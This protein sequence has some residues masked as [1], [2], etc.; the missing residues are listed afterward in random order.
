MQDL[1]QTGHISL[2]DAQLRY[3]PHFLSSEAADGLF[4][5]LL[6]QVTWKEDSIRI[7][8]KTYPQPRLTALYGDRGKSYAYSGIQMH[9]TPFTP[10]LL[11]LKLR[12][13]D[14]SGERFT[15]C[16]P[17]CLPRFS[18]KAQGGQVPEVSYATWAWE[19]AADGWRHA[20]ILVTS[21][22]QNPKNR[23]ET[24]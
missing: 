18:L 10:E 14:L 6:T 16:L 13:E 12:I 23:G 1:H 5:H 9:P 7:F 20:G 21:D 15:S 4:K 22:S 24:Y 2:R 11:D 3:E 19:P 17:G 8:G